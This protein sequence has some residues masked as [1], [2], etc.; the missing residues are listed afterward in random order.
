MV[1]DYSNMVVQSNIGLIYSGVDLKLLHTRSI[2][3]N[4][5]RKLLFVGRLV[6]YKGIEDI[7]EAV[8]TIPIEQRPRIDLVGEG[9]LRQKLQLKVNH[10][11]LNPWITFIGART[12][13]WIRQNG[14][15]YMA[16]VGAFK[17]AKDGSRDTGPVV[18]KEVMA[19]GLPVVTT[20]F[21]GCKEMITS[22][23][24]MN[25]APGDSLQLG[26]AMK[27]INSMGEQELRKMEKNGRERVASLYTADHQAQ[28]LSTLIVA[29]YHQN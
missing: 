18:V 16:L 9:E 22:Q 8:S 15:S 29:I 3:S 10:N 11:N 2:H 6:E 24:G 21:M 27:K 26:N 28:K 23:C 12:Q 14:P 13:E 5:N 17:P 25:V 7:I 20:N 4:S 19:M 1:N